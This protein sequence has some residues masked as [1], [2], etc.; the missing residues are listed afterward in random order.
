M[1]AHPGLENSVNYGR[2]SQQTRR[3]RVRAP[4]RS[5]WA[6]LVSLVAIILLLPPLT[7]AQTLYGT[8]IGNV[9]DA[10]GAAVAGATVVATNAG[11]GIAKTATTDNS[12]TFRLSDMEAGTYRVS[13][14]AKSFA[15]TVEQGIEIQTNT[16]RR[17]DVK[18]QPGSVGQTIVVTAALPELQT[19]TATV[20]SELE[21]E[22]VQTLVTT[23]GLNMRNFQS[24]L[25]LLPGFSPPGEQHS[26]SGNPADTMMFNANGVSGSNNSTRVDGVS[27]IYP[28][29]PEITAYTPSTEAISAVN[30]VTNSMNAEQ[31]FASGASVNVTTK[32]GT[33]QFHGTAWEYNMISALMA[34]N[35]FFVATPA[36]R[37]LIPK[38]VLNQFGANFGGPIKKNKAFFFGN[39]E[40][41]RRSQALSGFQT[42]PSANMLAG[43]F[44]GVTTNGTGHL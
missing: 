31:G 17:F 24:L 30:V 38:Y 13:I 26:E 14:S 27:D 39:W 5:V 3:A 9:T 43:N 16:E 42:V 1:H 41:T 22:Q 11:T 20:T 19:D 10:T 33:D 7:H 21:T 23:A 12:G 32:S 29:L 15:S 28:W 8:L 36:N 40:R 2:S 18:L 4:R 35:T 25:V 34:K 44:T 6:F 37:G